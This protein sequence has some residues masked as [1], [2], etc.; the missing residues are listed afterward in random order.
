MLAEKVWSNDGTALWVWGLG[1]F[2][3]R[4]WV[5]ESRV[6]GLGFEVWGLRVWDLGF[7]I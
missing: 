1:W 5:A 7:G 2:C 4:G 3:G 6:E